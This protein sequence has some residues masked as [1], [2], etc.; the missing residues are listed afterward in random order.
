MFSFFHLPFHQ[1]IHP[2]LPQSILLSMILSVYK[3]ICLSTYLSIHPSLHW[4]TYPISLNSLCIFLSAQMCSIHPLIH[5]ISI[6]LPIHMAT[7]I[8]IRD[9]IS[10]EWLYPK[11][12]TCWFISSVLCLQLFLRHPKFRDY[13][14]H[15]EW[16]FSRFGLRASS[17]LSTVDY[18]DSWLERCSELG[19]KAPLFSRHLC[20]LF[21]CC[22]KSPLPSMGP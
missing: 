18:W 9:T 2:T 10:S 11:F 7:Q 20:G 5:S 1:S 19:N 14:D 12:P 3:S 16:S 6:F 22:N 15:C 13:M 8:R 21:R 17:W 4:P